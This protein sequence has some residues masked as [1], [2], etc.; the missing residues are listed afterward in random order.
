MNT[1]ILCWLTAGCLAAAAL[2][3]AAI[4]R[5]A[6]HPAR[7]D[8][9][10]ARK[11]DN[12]SPY[13]T[14]DGGI[15]RPTDY[16]DTFE[17]LGSYAV[18]TKPDKPLDEMHV[19]YAR[20]EDVRAY[21][22]DGKFPDGATLVKEVTRVGSE[23]LTTGQSH[24]AT[25]IKLWFVM[26][27]DAKGR[28]PGN[29]LWGDGWGWALFLA[30]EPARNVATDY[31]TDCRTCHVPAKKDDWVYVRG[32]P[33]LREG[34]PGQMNRESNTTDKELLIPWCQ[35]RGQIAL[36][37]TA[38]PGQSLLKDVVLLG[39]A[40]SSAGEAFEAVR[41]RGASVAATTQGARI[42][43]LAYTTRR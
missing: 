14:K 15:S 20:P 33:V 21:R 24:W 2:V 8:A 41:R 30:K 7:S 42:S 16:R 4:A 22:R 6:S 1:K 27:K 19:V 11:A 37:V 35:R 5:G 9:P 38:M 10:P 28:F 36:W 31:S 18:A 3:A 29:D 13:V 23:K 40:L 25:D 12:F 26:I 17:Y 39:V 32:Y 43:E 34:P